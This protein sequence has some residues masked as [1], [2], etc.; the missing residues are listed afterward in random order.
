V[1]TAVSKLHVSIGGPSSL[2]DA[3]NE[4]GKAPGV[5]WTMLRSMV[6]AWPDEVY[7]KGFV[8]TRLLGQTTAFVV[9]PTLI[10]TL[11]VDEAGSLAREAFMTRALA[12]A[13]RAGVPPGSRPRLRAGHGGGG[14]GH[15]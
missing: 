14:T 11:L 1:A 12:P 5:L 4:A 6:D 13:L 15:P 10:R 3:L 9:D 2:R 8:E 7:T